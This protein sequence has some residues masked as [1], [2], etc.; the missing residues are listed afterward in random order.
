M[1]ENLSMDEEKL[2]AAEMW[3]YR[4]VLRTSWTERASNKIVLKKI[5]NR[6]NTSIQ[7]QEKQLEIFK[8]IMR[9][10]VLENLSLTWH[11]MGKRDR[12]K[13]RGFREP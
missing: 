4:R 1:L 8:H 7:N 6:K 5:D 3:T 11:N 13:H 9:N 2:V 12:G 10:G